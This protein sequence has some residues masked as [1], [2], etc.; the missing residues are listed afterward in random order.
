M[1]VTMI[2]ALVLLASAGAVGCTSKSA[3]PQEETQ[4]P[5]A[6][7][8]H[9]ELALVGRGS[10][11]HTYRLRQAIVMVQGP[12]ST[13]FF[14][15]EDYLT[16]PT[17][18]SDVVTGSYYAFLQE[19]WRLE[20]VTVGHDHGDHEHGDGGATGGSANGSVTGGDWVDPGSEDGGVGGTG[21]GE[22]TTGGT[23]GTTVETV[24]AHLVSGNPLFFEVYEGERTQVALRF[25]VGD[26]VVGM[27]GGFDISLEVDETPAGPAP[28]YCTSDSECATGETCCVAGFLGQ[29]RTLGEGE[30]CPLPDLTVS[31]EAAAA[32]LTIRHDNFPAD[33]CAIVEGCVGGSGDRRLL[34]FTTF[35]PNIGEAD[36][37][38][39]DPD[40]APGFVYSQCHGHD[41]FEG[42]AS[43][44]LLD[45]GGNVVATGHKQAFC[46]L[47]SAPAVPG[48]SS[49][50]RY[51][52]G[53]Q[54][55]QAGWGD[56]YDSNLDCQWVDITDVPTGDYVLAISINPSRTLPESN[57]DNNTVTVP[58]HVGEDV[59]P[60]PGDVLAACT[61]TVYGDAR[62]CGWSIPEGMQG[63]ACEPGAQIDLGCGCDVD[64]C[65]GDPVLR[66]CEG[67]Q[68]CTAAAALASADDT[69]GR[70]PEATL[71][72]PASGMY[73]VLTAAY[74]P[75]TPFLCA[76]SIQSGL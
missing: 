74:E 38:L 15:S 7:L 3:E 55:I 60:E 69:C 70:C 23:S 5:K 59:I 2:S 37:I 42:Y 25:Q 39:G 26:E 4:N 45:Q 18:S 48:A 72:C 67:D 17:L 73:T 51:H 6:D 9:M 41:H 31:E 56:A 49:S 43:Y 8:G 47:D 20:R 57:Y 65:N 71:T 54:G 46:L 34:A 30:S 19:G 62:D 35:T 33:S 29:C 63:V 40:T 12:T 10:L 11:G 36:M 28:G 68:P 61:S 13:E 76:P 14:D 44:E 24:D 50:P 21:G 75:G 58:V 22:G 16:R 52:C 64:T 53:F 66:V 32:S 1:R 27:M